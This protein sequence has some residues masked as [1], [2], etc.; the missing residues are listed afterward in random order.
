MSTDARLR[1]CV[2]CDKPTY[3]ECLWC[4]QPL[5]RHVE[6]PSNTEQVEF[7][8]CSLYC[9]GSSNHYGGPNRKNHTFTVEG[10]V[11][12]AVLA[13]FGGILI[14]LSVGGGTCSLAPECCRVK[15]L[16]C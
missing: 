1:Q 3:Q 8:E 15:W 4:E 14:L 7:T 10:E 11:M 5:H 6:N 12:E 13:T 16:N 9:P 2:V